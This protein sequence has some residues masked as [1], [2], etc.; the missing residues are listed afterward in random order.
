MHAGVHVNSR[1]VWL[2]IRCS[3]V[4]RARPLTSAYADKRRISDSLS[5]SVYFF[6]F[7]LLMEGLIVVGTELVQEIVGFVGKL[8]VVQDCRGYFA[9]KSYNLQ[10]VALKPAAHSARFAALELFQ[11]KYFHH[12]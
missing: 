11:V 2:T 10:V 9:Q 6:V 8:P 3:A 1:S 5:V 7:G 12:L 4:G